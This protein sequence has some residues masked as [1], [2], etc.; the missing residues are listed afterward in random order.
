MASSVVKNALKAIRERGLGNFF[1][2]LKEEGYLYIP[3]TSNSLTFPFNCISLSNFRNKYLIHSFMSE[4]SMFLFL[5]A[6]QI[7]FLFPNLLVSSICER[8]QSCSALSVFFFFFLGLLRK[9]FLFLFPEPIQNNNSFMIEVL[10][11][12][13][14]NLRKPKEIEL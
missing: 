11:L 12:S 14:R 9:W 1:R 3:D 8:S 6:N 7:A 13:V 5:N 10:V 2:E 4:N